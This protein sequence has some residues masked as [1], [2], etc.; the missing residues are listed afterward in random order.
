MI[1]GYSI[2]VI[3]RRES[4]HEGSRVATEF[5]VDWL[6]H[7]VQLARNWRLIVV[8]HLEGRFALQRGS[9]SEV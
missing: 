6:Y 1:A 9:R 7:V 3:K 4:V 5:M 8:S 2:G